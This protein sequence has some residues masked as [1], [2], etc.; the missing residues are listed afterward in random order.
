MHC[1]D[2]SSDRVITLA[3]ECNLDASAAMG[4]IPMIA[5][6]IADGVQKVIIDCSKV[7][8]MD[9]GLLRMIVISHNSLSSNGGV[10]ELAQVSTQLTE[11]LEFTG[12][13]SLLSH[14]AT[15]GGHD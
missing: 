3:P 1:I 6:A 9:A 14:T 13:K 2:N 11:L 15:E 12:L 7:E 10:L 8:S 5:S 4:I